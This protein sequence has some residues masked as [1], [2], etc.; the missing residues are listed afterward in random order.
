M[1]IHKDVYE[2]IVCEMASILSR[3]RWV[4]KSLF[5]EKKVFLLIYYWYV[6]WSIQLF[7]E[8]CCI[9]MNLYIYIYIYFMQNKGLACCVKVLKFCTCAYLLT[10]K[11]D[12]IQ[13]F[14]HLIYDFKYNPWH[15]K[16][17]TISPFLTSLTTISDQKV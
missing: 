6:I 3:G 10:C 12:L 14:L 17:L 13:L 1:F 8:L 5:D 16:N 11:C 15:S 4:K 2:I 7:R 9:L